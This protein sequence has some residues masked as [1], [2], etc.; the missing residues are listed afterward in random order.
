[1]S[2]KSRDRAAV[3]LAASRRS[4]K[5]GVAFA[6]VPL[7]APFSTAGCNAAATRPTIKAWLRNPARPIRPFM[8]DLSVAFT[9]AGGEKVKWPNGP[10]P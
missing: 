5:F 7:A 3:V 9:R 8:N 4:K 2:R 1:L 6:L 10:Q